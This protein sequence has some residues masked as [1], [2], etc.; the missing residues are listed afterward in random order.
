MKNQ[1]RKHDHVFDVLP[2]VRQSYGPAALFASLLLTACNGSSIEGV[3]NNGGSGNEN[4]VVAEAKLAADDADTLIKESM[5]GY[6]TN[7]DNANAGGAGGVA[8][9]VVFAQENGATADSSDDSTASDARFSDTNVQEAGVDE[10][11]RVKIDG[12]VMFALERPSSQHIGIF[13]VQ[14][15]VDISDAASDSIMPFA[16]PQETLSAYRL[17][18]ENSETLSRMKLELGNQRPEGMYL[19]KNGGKRD[20]VL[21]SKQS[22]NAWESWGNT[23][24]FSGLRTRV[25]WIDASD[26]TNLSIDRTLDVDGQLISSRKINNRLIFVT[27]HHPQVPGIQV[28]YNAEVAESNRAKIEAADINSMLPQYVLDIGGNTTTGPVV[29]DNRCY[30]NEVVKPGDNDNADIDGADAI[31]PYYVNPS[32][33]SII[34]VDLNDQSTKINNTCFV[35]DTE[36]MY[37]STQALYL[38][39][40]QYDYNFGSDSL[41]RPF[42]TYYPPEITTEI[43]KFSFSD[44]GSPQ[45]RGTGSVSGH[46]GWYPDRKPFRMSE[47]DNNLRVVT[48]DENRSGSPVTLNILAEGD[49]ASM[50]TLSTLPNDN[51]PAPIGKPGENL[52]ASRF[53]GDRAYLVTFRVTDPLYVLDVSDPY[54]PLIAGELE[55]PGYSDYLHPVSDT[56]LVGV[57]KDAVADDGSGWGDGRGAWFQGVKLALFDVSDSSNPFVADSKVIGKRGTDTP[58]LYSH[59]SFA[60]LAQGDGRNA[61]MAMPL[62]LHDG[63]KSGSG[64]SAWATWKSNGILTMEVDVAAN[65]FVDVPDWTFESTAAG[66][67]FSPVSLEN[68][69]AV[70]GADG[71]LYVIHNGSLQYGLWGSSSPVAATR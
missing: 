69:R 34:T 10:S 28:P 29:T 8:I 13:P 65:A 39:T 56:L 7:T 3:A 31:S 43:H 32:I 36:T 25:T 70:I 54:D 15:E 60:W 49:G 30:K 42:I 47:K 59:H 64:P 46:L 71:G 50:N 9:D 11:D 62:S 23:M 19:H 4:P 18:K 33:I 2:A 1:H 26:E 48:F 61:R 58:A 12:N 22:F 53:I 44:G 55:L 21:L 67:S 63:E 35:G 20:L 17:A 68:D 6:Y 66:H 27:R 52:Y 38:A 5:L 24:A 57:G 41:S 14:L 51:R 40:T 16:E 45:F 37:V